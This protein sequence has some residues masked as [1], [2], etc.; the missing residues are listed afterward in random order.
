MCES[1]PGHDT[2]SSSEG[3]GEVQ[4]GAGHDDSVNPPREEHVVCEDIVANRISGAYGEFIEFMREKTC[5]ICPAGVKDYQILDRTSGRKYAFSPADSEMFFTRVEGARID[6][7][8]LHLLEH[9]TDAP[10]GVMIDIDR[11]QGSVSQSIFDAGAMMRANITLAGIITKILDQT[12]DD[13]HDVLGDAS[14]LERD[15]DAMCADDAG[16]STDATD[17]RAKIDTAFHIFIIKREKIT[18]AA[19]GGQYKDGIHLLVPDLWC[20]KAIRA[21]IVTQFAIRIGEIFPSMSREEVRE[22]VDTNSSSVPPHLVGS[23]KLGGVMYKLAS[24]VR[25]TA[26]GGSN[27]VVPLNVDSL[28]HGLS[29]PISEDGVGINLVYELSLT[30]NMPSIHKV[31]T[32]LHKRNIPISAERERVITERITS[33]H[34]RSGMVARAA[35]SER[36]RTF[37][38]EV[39]TLIHSDARASYINELL[40]ALEPKYAHEYGLWRNVLM[41]ISHEAVTMRREEYKI[42]ARVFSMRDAE[43]WN[44]GAFDKMWSDLC[45]RTRSRASYDGNAI[46]VR[47]LEFWVRETNGNAFNDISK[48]DA[49]TFLRLSIYGSG[50][51]ITNVAIAEALVRMFHGRFAIDTDCPDKLSRTGWY[52]FIW[53]DRLQTAFK[54]YFINVPHAIY[55][56]IVEN[57]VPI[58]RTIETEVSKSLEKADSD[59]K[60]A[61]LT[62]IM[63]KLSQSLRTL[64]SDRTQG[65]IVRQLGHRVHIDGFAASLDTEPYV[66]GVLG[67]VLE[68]LPPK[69]YGSAHGVRAGCV[70]SGCFATV[71]R[72][73]SASEGSGG[74]MSA[75]GRDF[76]QYPRLIK[77][78]HNHRVLTFAPTEYVPFDA[79]S[80]YVCDILRAYRDIY[81]EPDVSEFVLFY[82]STWLDMC[83]SQRM[84]LLL[85]GGGSN[86]KSWSVLFPQKVLGAKYVKVLRMQLLTD[87]QRGDSGVANSALMS[88]KGCRGGYFDEAN[89]GETINPASM[90]SMVTPGDQS[91]R[92]LFSR[93]EQFRNT[94]NTIAISNYDFIINATDCGTWD[95]TRYYQ[96]RARFVAN[97][98]PTNPCEKLKRPEMTSE[99]VEDPRYRSAMLSILV[100]YRIRLEREFGGYLDRIPIPTIERETKAFRAKQDPIMRFISERLVKSAGVTASVN[101]I[102]DSYI[103]WYREL[104]HTRPQHINGITNM[105]Q[106]SIISSYLKTSE[107]GE[108]AAQGLRLREAHDHIG[109]EESMI[110]A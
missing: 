20:P 71:G 1:Q 96:C 99:W 78:F 105:F 46:T 48:R 21:F 11:K 30:H 12:E 81:I 103:D 92:E 68:F 109:A 22:L 64:E 85:G 18:Q 98:D 37:E 101:A 6:G 76:S 51:T 87:K 67:G 86:G 94:A 31:P 2:S 66:I 16:S 27:T 108:Y 9:V 56:F 90:K 82:L 69:E 39:E 72:D 79:A 23:C 107:N 42:L 34:A 44:E 13:Q 104:N 89:E 8:I 59:S 49:T 10:A 65:D 17:P 77:G 83:D 3:T 24:A 102:V 97:P 93:E 91:A 95:R 32:W 88:L 57:I 43:K 47:S 53:E 14:R 106:N 54:W 19:S 33:V 70:T 73:T 84:I 52:E 28:A 29:A 61:A 40:G 36:A 60:H 45:A 74:R 58:C 25:V 75:S 62:M 26:I 55:I 50:G 7:C 4:Y 63:K 110:V 35:A 41:A 15:C 100:H 5:S 38:D 80:P